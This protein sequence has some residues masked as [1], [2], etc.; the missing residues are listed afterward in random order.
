GTGGKVV[1]AS[2]P[3]VLNVSDM[4]VQPD[5][6]IV[7]VG[8][9]GVATV[10]FCVLRY[11][12]DGSLDGTF[13][14]GGRVSTHFPNGSHF[15]PPVPIR[16]DGRVVVGGTSD[17]LVS[18]FVGYLPNGAVDR[19][20][21]NNGKTTFDVP[22]KAETIRDIAIQADGKIVAVGDAGRDILVERLNENGLIDE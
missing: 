11:D 8:P 18:S 1:T 4:A 6:K 5:G 13:G 3:D 10:D 16:L 12:T 2:A 14:V 9:C 15:S 7:V 17:L 20:F 22:G 21:G 19:D